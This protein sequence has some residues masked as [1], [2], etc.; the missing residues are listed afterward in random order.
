MIIAPEPPDVDGSDG[1]LFGSAPCA[2]P[3]NPDPALPPLPPE[4]NLYEEL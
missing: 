3:P 1:I 2:P 4:Q